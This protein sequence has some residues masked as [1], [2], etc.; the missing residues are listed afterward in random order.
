MRLFRLSLIAIVTA[1]CSSAPVQQRTPTVTGGPPFS[2]VRPGAPANAL[3]WE[4]QVVTF[5][6][7][8]RLTAGLGS[9]ILGSTYYNNLTT[10]FDAGWA[11]ISWTGANASLRA[12]LEGNVFAGLPVTGFFANNRDNSVSDAG[13]LA[14]Y[15]AL[16]RHRTE[17]DCTNAAGAC[18]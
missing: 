11:R 14:N 1:A 5:N 18:S 4:A 6:Q 15:T 13:V 7:G 9:E 2:P 10:P 17:R 8:D 16:F 3:C 12:S